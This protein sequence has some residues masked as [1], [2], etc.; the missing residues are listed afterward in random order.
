MQSVSAA[1]QRLDQVDVRLGDHLRAALLG[2]VE[3]VLVERVLGAGATADHAAAAERAPGAARALAAEVRVV[4]LDVGLAEVD[5]HRGGVECVPEAA[6]LGNAPQRLVAGAEARARHRAEHPPGGGVVRRHHAT[7][8]L[9]LLPQRVVPHGLLGRE[10]GVGVEQAAA[11]HA[12]AGEDQ[13]VPKQVHPP[14]PVA[15]YPRQPERARDVPVGPG[16]LV[17]PPALPL[18]HHPDL[19]PL[20]RK[21]QR[22]NGAAET[23]A[24]DDGVDVEVLRGRSRQAARIVCHTPTLAAYSPVRNPAASRQRQA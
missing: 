3:V 21:P 18:L 17:G 7:P 10:V 9:E 8:R 22:G 4:G 15:A 24:D 6:P 23:R 5:A 13:E 1:G 19:V 11:A 16:K 2:E 14:D 12:D 20:L